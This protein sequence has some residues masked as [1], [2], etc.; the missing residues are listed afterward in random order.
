MTEGKEEKQP[1][2]LDEVQECLEHLLSK[3]NLAE[4]AFLKRRMNAQLYIPLCVLA[5]HHSIARFGQAA[6]LDT[7]LKAA[8]RS[9]EVTLD[10]ENLAV[11]PV[12]R[13]KR[14]T[15][16]LHALPDDVAE[17]ELHELFKAAPE[18]LCSVKPDVNHTAFITFQTDEAAQT[19]A[20]WLRSQK[21]RGESVKCAIKTEHVVR[22]FF[23]AQHVPT[24]PAWAAPGGKGQ[25]MGW[26][27]PWC[28]MMAWDV[29]DMSDTCGFDGEGSTQQMNEVGAGSDDKGLAANE[30]VEVGYMH[31]FRSYPRQTIIEVCSSMREVTK[32]ESFA[33]L[34]REDKNIALFRTSPC[35]DWAPLPTPMM[36]FV[37]SMLGS[38]GRKNTGG[39][40][41][42]DHSGTGGSRRRSSRPPR[43]ASSGRGGSDAGGDGGGKGAQQHHSTGGGGGSSNMGA[44]WGG[45]V[46][47]SGSS[48]PRETRSHDWSGWDWSAAGME[49][50]WASER[51]DSRWR[52]SSRKGLG[53]GEWY[54][55]VWQ[56]KTT[57]P[58]GDTWEPKVS[59]AEGKVDDIEGASSGEKPDGEGE[60]GRP[61][62]GGSA[63]GGE[64]SVVSK[65]SA[66]PS[67][68]GTPVAMAAAVQTW[69]EKVSSPGRPSPGSKA[70]AALVEAVVDVPEAPAAPARPAAQSW[71]DKVRLGSSGK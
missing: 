59:Q 46:G 6:T 2:Q 12:M 36:S 50:S 65:I 48:G 71:A 44:Q 23:P 60:A 52:T 1:D 45:H 38:E 41:Q 37:S 15:V 70:A 31:E 35:K 43:K 22:S 9:T 18:T 3:E 69:A 25:G 63:V 28:P 19:V 5:N 42:D 14:N 61:A 49:T 13:Q 51:S 54:G 32:P 4:D 68:E 58:R 20:L 55:Q 11:R 26:Q 16:I 27:A 21:L 64:A 24:E 47:R 10:T 57:A 56:E 8:E 7:L 66:G 17:E 67:G 34:E 29:G 30:E 40:E 39:E 53:W 33:K 62:D